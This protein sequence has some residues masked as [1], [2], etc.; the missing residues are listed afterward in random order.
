VRHLTV[1]F[2][3]CLLAARPAGA[4][5]DV[6]RAHGEVRELLAAGR[7]DEAA[8]RLQALVAAAPDFA[9]AWYDLGYARR[10]L[11]QYGEAVRAYTRYTQ[12][13]PGDPGALFGL[14]LSQKGAG[15]REAAVRAL[16][17][18][19]EREKRAAEQRWVARAKEV[20]AELTAPEPTGPAAEAAPAPPRAPAPAPAAAPAEPPAVAAPRL[21]AEADRARAAGKLALA[22]EKYRAAVTLSPR[23][24]DA[25]NELG[26]VYFELKRY[27]EAAGAF[28]SALKLDPVFSLGWYN[29]GQ[30]LRRL[31]RNAEAVEAY[32]RY[33]KLRPGDP[34]PWYSLG[35]ARKDVGDLRGA[36][37]ALERYVALEK[38]PGEARYVE[39]A[40]G[41]VASLV[42]QIATGAPP[43]RPAPAPA[44]VPAAAAAPPPPPVAVAP[45]PPP[46]AVAPPP[47]PPRPAP[48]PVE[49]E[50]RD[51]V[52]AGDRAVREGDL[53]R[54]T[55]RYRE[56]VERDAQNLALRR[57]LGQ[58][59]TDTGRLRDAIAQ[60][61]LVS[62]QGKDQAARQ[63]AERL[64]A[65]LAR[66]GEPAAAAVWRVREMIAAGRLAFAMAD[67]ATLVAARPKDAEVLCLRGQVAL[68][69]GDA[70]AALADANAALALAP[71]RPDALFLAAEALRGTDR[72]KA[73]SAYEAYLQH[74]AADPGRRYRAPAAQ[75][76]LYELT[77]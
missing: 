48:P 36:V 19:V 30:S 54:A 42:R 60:W 77:K 21:K 63:I 17:S 5:S 41:L 20:L 45:P 31:G 64:R 12:L 43:P 1:A 70:A 73:I 58:V 29:L 69:R 22:I 49:P 46:V 26:N 2:C 15:N 50:P 66:S 71:G 61:D 76:A 51:P 34:D 65:Q 56:A 13:R 53:A 24:I 47:P 57:K 40:R 59:L 23:F 10:R 32:E 72:A 7:F 3:L 39:A 9:S 38:R 44:V 52:A 18:Y 11:G 4:Q 37:A 14:G 33:T 68:A 62:W 55:M 8:R 27:E 6:A 28:R 25:W 74:A 67:A 35:L 16:R 75:R